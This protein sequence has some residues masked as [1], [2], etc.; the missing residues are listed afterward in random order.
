MLTVREPG[1]T[2]EAEALREL[3]LGGEPGRWSARE[4]MLLM[5]AARAH[6][7]RTLIAPALAR[8][9]WV[10]S[11]RFADSTLVYQGLAGGVPEQDIRQLHHLVLGDFNPDLTL[12]LDIEPAS[13][14]T[15]VR[16]RAEALNQF[17]RRQQAFYDDARAAYLHLA[18]EEPQ[19]C[20]VIN[21]GQK[22]DEVFAQIL[23][24]VH[25]NT[26]LEI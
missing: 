6:L 26:G 25:E 13:G 23:N 2:A 4:E 21:A 19:R 3:V 9:T 16:S 24:V 18:S 11:D 8:G 10:L 15:R 12:I 1:G 5:Y 14:M 20:K 17:E 22:P 7:V